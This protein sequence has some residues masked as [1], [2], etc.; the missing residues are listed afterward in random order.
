MNRRGFF[1]GLIAGAAACLG[2]RAVV[3]K[4]S[5]RR[6]PPGTI[7]LV[8]GPVEYQCDFGLGPVRVDAGGRVIVPPFDKDKCRRELEAVLSEWQREIKALLRHALER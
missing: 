3:A 5:V 7:L 1:A 8:N 4:T 2:V 6:F